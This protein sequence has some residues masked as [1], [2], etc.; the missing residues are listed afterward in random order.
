MIDVCFFVICFLG[1]VLFRVVV[2]VVVAY[3]P[4]SVVCC[5]LLFVVLVGCS[6]FVFV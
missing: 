4:L 2:F 3:D 5:L 6:P 1:V